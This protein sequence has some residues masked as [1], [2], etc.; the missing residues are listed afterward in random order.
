MNTP[1]SSVGFWV[2]A[3]AL[4][5]TI[6]TLL[7]SIQKVN[8]E[9]VKLEEENEKLKNIIDNLEE[10]RNV[11]ENKLKI[12][13][14]EVDKLEKE[15]KKLKK[16]IDKK[17]KE[18]KKKDKE[19]KE[20]KNK[21][22]KTMTMKLTHYTMYCDGC[23]GRTASGYKLSHGQTKYNGYVIVAADTSILPLHSK[24]KII[25][26]DGS[27][28]KAIVLDRGGAI[29]GNRLDVLTATKEEAYRKGVYNAQVEVLSYGD[30]KYRK[31]N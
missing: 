29:K 6:S 2:L 4:C 9:K 18:I 11:L 7:F 25:N 10:E 20:L 15:N 12:K 5:I 16:D 3:I 13:I 17:N 19:I 30:N 22:N 27:S 26:P 28:F 14:E 31:I 23:T 1:S 21:K 8:T 24:I